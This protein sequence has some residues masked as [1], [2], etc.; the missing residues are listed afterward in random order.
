[1]SETKEMET[2]AESL[3]EETMVTL[4]SKD[5]EKF[6][7][8]SKVA[9]MSVL[10]KTTL[11][12]DP[13]AREVA[14]ATVSSAVLKKMLEFMG[15]HVDKP[16][17]EIEKPIKSTNM[18]EVVCKWDA[19]FINLDNEELFALILASNWMD[20]KSLLDLGCAKIASMIK[21]KSPEEIRK[22]FDITNDF[23]PEEEAAV[24]AENKWAEE[25]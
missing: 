17:A 14:L 11:E 8:A 2:G 22:K 25:S 20:V 13:T 1:M 15:Y 18:E 7:V 3:D 4:V 21:G 16:C 19:D 24:R 12:G 10:I 23:T 5:N 9:R 6:E